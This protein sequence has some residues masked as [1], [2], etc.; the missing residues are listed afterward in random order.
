MAGFVYSPAS[1]DY[2]AVSQDVVFPA[3][4]TQRSVAIPIVED[5][6]LEAM[7]FFSVSI[8]VQGDSDGVVLGVS[9]VDVYI[10]NDDGECFSS[11][12]SSERL[13]C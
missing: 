4:T 6:V 7:E 1:S 12:I 5:S 11:I 8:S 3:G 13:E 9:S 2:Y 10:Q